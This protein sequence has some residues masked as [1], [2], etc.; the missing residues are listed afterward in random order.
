MI[1]PRLKVDKL[2]QK[3]Q[4]SLSTPQLDHHPT[5]DEGDSL[6]AEVFLNKNSIMT[7]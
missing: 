7:K 2:P 4:N 5:L 3:L 1:I 6:T